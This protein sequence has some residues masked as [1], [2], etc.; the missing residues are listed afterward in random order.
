MKIEIIDN[1][2]AKGDYAIANKIPIEMSK[3]EKTAYGNEWRTYQEINT[4]PENHRDQ[5]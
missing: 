4:N 5:A 2:I 1:D 3:S